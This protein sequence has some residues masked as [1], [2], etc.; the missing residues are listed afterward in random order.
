MSCRKILH[1]VQSKKMLKQVF[2]IF[3]PLIINSQDCKEL[4][5]GTYN[6]KLP[7]QCDTK[8]QD[9]ND[10]CNDFMEICASCQHIGCDV[11]RHESPC[12]CNPNCMK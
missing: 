11:H 10:C 8:C 2:L 1:T 5:C 9:T 7:C 12:Q 3:I 6:P 4:G